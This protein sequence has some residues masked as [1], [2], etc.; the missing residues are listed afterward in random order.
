MPRRTAIEFQNSELRGL[1]RRSAAFVDRQFV[2][3]KLSQIWRNVTYILVNFFPFLVRGFVT[4]LDTRGWTNSCF[5]AS[6]WLGF[7]PGSIFNSHFGWKMNQVQIFRSILVEILVST[8]LNQVWTRFEPGSTWLKNS[9]FQPGWRNECV[10]GWS[11]NQVH[12]FHKF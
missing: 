8:R 1:W 2:V 4:W 6:T 7:E 9:N 10:L 11:V 12:D 3:L 5:R